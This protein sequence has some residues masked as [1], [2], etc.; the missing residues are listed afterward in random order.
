MVSVNLLCAFVFMKVVKRK[1]SPFGLPVPCRTYLPPGSWCILGLSLPEFSA[2]RNSSTIEYVHLAKL[3][4]YKQQVLNLLR[5]VGQIRSHSDQ[6]GLH[7]VNYCTDKVNIGRNCESSG[8]V[9]FCT[10]D[11]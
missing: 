8:L 5:L 2:T 9:G 6:M 4:S 7:K 10:T 1:Y 3:V 11:H